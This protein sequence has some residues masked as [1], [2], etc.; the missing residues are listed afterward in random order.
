MMKLVQCF[1]RKAVQYVYNR[2]DG[3]HQSVAFDVLHDDNVEII[4]IIEIYEMSLS[5]YLI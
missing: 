3:F 5:I 1:K 2:W 4:T